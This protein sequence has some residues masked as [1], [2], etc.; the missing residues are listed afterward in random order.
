MRRSRRTPGL[1]NALRNH[2]NPLPN[3]NQRRPHQNEIRLPATRSPFQE[4]PPERPSPVPDPPRQDKATS[5]T[6][7][8]ALS[9]PEEPSLDTQKQSPPIAKSQKPSPTTSLRNDRTLIHPS[10]GRT[11]RGGRN[12]TTRPSLKLSRISTLPASQTS[13]KPGPSERPQLS[14]D[15]ILSRERLLRALFEAGVSM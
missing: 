8:E 12:S 14:Q 1:L 9:T 2:C 15:P 6:A 10:R 3:R 11:N 13:S 4:S 7:T 5:A